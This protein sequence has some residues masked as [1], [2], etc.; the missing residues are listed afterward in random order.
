M[1]PVSS[2]LRANVDSSWNYDVIVIF[3]KLSNTVIFSI[4]PKSIF[5]IYHSFHFFICLYTYSIQDKIEEY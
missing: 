5:D 1:A 4:I 2:E 3:L